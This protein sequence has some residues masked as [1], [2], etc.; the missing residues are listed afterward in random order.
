MKKILGVVVIATTLGLIGCGSKH[1]IPAPQLRKSVA[2]HCL[3]TDTDRDIDS[4]AGTER[5][6]ELHSLFPA[7]LLSPR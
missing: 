6:G 4:N 7:V 3:D 5:P 1:A 2:S